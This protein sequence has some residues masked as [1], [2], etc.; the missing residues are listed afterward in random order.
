MRNDQIKISDFDQSED[1]FKEV[2]PL[3]QNLWDACE[4]LGLPMTLM[5]C[6]A[7]KNTNSR[8]ASS[9]NSR[10]GWAPTQI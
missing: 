7:K 5:C 2:Q 8:V 6:Y 1:F 9:L 3:I 10:D 4:K